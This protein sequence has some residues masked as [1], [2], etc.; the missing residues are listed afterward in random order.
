[1]S[2]RKISLFTALVSALAFSLLYLAPFFNAAEL[3][4][5]DLFL[6]FVSTRKR[7]DNVVFLDVDDPAIAK[8]GVFPWPRRVMAEGLLWLKEFNA[9]LAIFDI[10]YI[11]KSPTHVDELY[12]QKGLAQDYNRRFS[13]I[14]TSVADI[15]GAVSTGRIPPERVVSYIDEITEI[16]TAERDA[17]YR[18]TMKITSDEDLLLAQSAALFGNAW[19]TLNIQDERP[20]SGEQAE[21]GLLAEQQFSYA[22]KKA[23]GVPGGKNVDV[24]PPIPLFMQAVRG[25]GF[26]NITVDPDGVRRRIFLA[27]EVK[28]R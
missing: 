10:E 9:E 12:L 6:R 8:I 3:R 20:L 22:I 28:G 24:L 19:G 2:L 26:I 7:I 25:A 18:E 21:R 1:M 13:E 27:Q 11:D 17:L 4:I 16:I 23:K 15:L 5:Y 14:G